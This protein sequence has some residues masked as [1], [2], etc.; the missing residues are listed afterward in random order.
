MTAPTE[1]DSTAKEEFG[2]ATRA[3]A[4]F[5]H[6]CGICAFANRKPQT[7]FGRLMRWHRTWCPCWAAHTKVYGEKPLS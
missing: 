2:A 4:N 5:C 6:K 7:L 1:D 3:M